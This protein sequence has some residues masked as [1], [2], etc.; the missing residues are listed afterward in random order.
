MSRPSILDVPGIVPALATLAGIIIGFALNWVRDVRSERGRI[1][2]ERRRLAVALLAEIAALRHGY[3][4]HIVAPLEKWKENERLEIGEPIQVANFF[5]VYDGNTGTLGLF[6]SADVQAVVR[7]Y[8]LAKTHAASLN[9]IREAIRNVLGQLAT[10]QATRNSDAVK[11]VDAS[12]ITLT[13]AAVPR[14]RKES[15]VLLKLYD[16]ASAALRK[17]G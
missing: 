12:L 5:A 14:L 7:A 10:F 2:S 1:A 13:N 6:E 4:E 11:S 15:E 8:T 9:V 3:S 17:Y 16:E